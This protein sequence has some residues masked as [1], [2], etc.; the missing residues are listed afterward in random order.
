M[1][2]VK[3]YSSREEKANYLTHAF[4]V[5]MAIIAAIVLLCRSVT[6]GSV[7]AIV[8]YSIFGFGMLACMLSSTIY[9]YVQKPEP[10]AVLRHFDH[11]NI[12]VL[13]ASTY[14][15]FTLILLRNER[16]WGWGLFI[17]I[18]LIAFVGITFTLGTLKAN[19]HLKTASYVF[20]GMCIL[21]AIKPFIDV[22]R[23][24][25]CMAVLYWLAAGGIFY[26]A[27]SFLYALAKH[28]FVHTVFHVFVLFGLACHII[29]AYL[30]PL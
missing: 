9:H 29:A 10:K 26:I 24:E 17:L 6:A 12:Y 27:G 1:Q 2:I 5:I 13:I 8:A 30:I 11:A 16:F 28:E 20:M 25:N 15:P 7:W 3:S 14:S 21:I 23:A 19:N 22:A 18:W 4:G